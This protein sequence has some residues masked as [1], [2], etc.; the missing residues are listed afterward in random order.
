MDPLVYF[1]QWDQSAVFF[2]I[3]HPTLTSKLTSAYFESLS[4]FAYEVS[5]DIE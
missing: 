1:P 5:A 4:Y 3:S 2:T